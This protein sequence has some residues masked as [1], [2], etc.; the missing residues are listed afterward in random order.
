M[1]NELLK[2]LPSNNESQKVS[3]IKLPWKKEAIKA[4]AQ[5]VKNVGLNEIL[6]VDIGAEDSKEVSKST[7]KDCIGTIIDID[8]DW[9]EALNFNAQQGDNQELCI[10]PTKNNKAISRNSKLQR[11]RPKVKNDDFLWN[12]V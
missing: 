12:W 7:S 10:N 9:K 2:N 5:I 4:G 11:N 8:A 3:A 1:S 6:N